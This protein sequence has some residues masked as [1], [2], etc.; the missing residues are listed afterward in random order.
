MPHSLRFVIVIVSALTVIAPISNAWAGKR[1]AVLDIEDAPNKRLRQAIV[2]ILRSKKHTVISV[3]TFRRTAKRLGAETLTSDNLVKVATKLR[4]D[5]ILSGSVTEERGKYY[6]RLHLRSGKTGETVQKL[7]L[8]LSRARLSKKIRRQLQRQLMVA[9]KALVPISGVANDERDD[10]DDALEVVSGPKAKP[11][12]KSKRGTKTGRSGAKTRN[13][14]GARVAVKSNDRKDENSGKATDGSDAALKGAGTSS[15]S[16]MSIRNRP[17]ATPKPVRRAVSIDM[18][19]SVVKRNL[20]FELADEFPQAPN[21]Y[22][23]PAALGLNVAGDLYPL[24]FTSLTGSIFASLGFAFRYDR[25][26]GLQTAVNAGGEQILAPTAQ[27][28]YSVGV[29]LRYRF[30]GLPTQPTI[31]LGA[32]KG[33]LTFAVDRSD[34]PPGLALDVPNTGYAYYDPT[35]SL[36][37]SVHPRVDVGA[38][39]QVLLITDAGDVQELDQYGAATLTSF[40]AH[41]GIEFRAT[42]HWRVRA[43]GSYT[44]V[45]LDFI[46]NGEQ[47]YARDGDPSDIDVLSASDSYLGGSLTVGYVY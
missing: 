29:R 33:M 31:T 13:R 6:L 45:G 26:L 8:R 47:T 7:R 18:G 30:S 46:G 19:T 24:E 12:P 22:A 1:I 34:L 42:A 39:A 40:A 37:L 25:V 5:G 44:S 38:G 20:T 27:H 2:S 32:G 10:G 15:D 4:A 41:A 17:R 3:R 11:I 9:V 28:S 16:R 35:I 21:G 14:K 43:T 23:G 36:H